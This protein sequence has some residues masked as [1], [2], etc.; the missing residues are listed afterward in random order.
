MPRYAAFA[1][2][3]MTLV[4]R[5]L[6]LLGAIGR[7]LG[8]MAYQRIGMAGYGLGLPL[9]AF[10]LSRFFHANEDPL[11]TLQPEEAC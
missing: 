4:N 2:C 3:G 9:A 5:T 1:T 6:S 8:D 10:V 11:R 7:I